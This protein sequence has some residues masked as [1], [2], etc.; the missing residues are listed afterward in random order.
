MKAMTDTMKPIWQEFEKQLRS[1]LKDINDA[2][3]QAFEK[4]VGIVSNIATGAVIPDRVVRSTVE[5]FLGNLLHRQGLAQSNVKKAIKE[6]GPSLTKLHSDA[7]SPVR[8]A[9]IG[10]L[11]E[12]TYRRANLVRGK[13]YTPTPVMNHALLTNKYF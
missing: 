2:I 12:V 3:M 10:T 1:K 4:I 7:F 5:T 13:L 6:F 8:S 11:M 9:I